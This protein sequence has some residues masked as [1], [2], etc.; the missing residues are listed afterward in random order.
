[1]KIQFLEPERR[2]RRKGA[3]ISVV[4]L[5]K[6]LEWK[7]EIIDKFVEFVKPKIFEMYANRVPTQ[8][9]LSQFIIKEWQDFIQFQ[10]HNIQ[11]KRDTSDR[12]AFIETR[13]YFSSL[14]VRLVFTEEE[15]KYIQYLRR[16]K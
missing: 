4:D 10:K 8:T 15:L 9:Q 12:K 5:A 2:H 16:F 14:R 7:Y 1:M 6:I 13:D 11:L 3:V